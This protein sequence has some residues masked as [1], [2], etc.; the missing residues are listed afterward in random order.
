MPVF[1]NVPAVVGA[2]SVITTVACPPLARS[3]RPQETTLFSMTHGLDAPFTVAATYPVPSAR[4]SV[5]VAAVAVEPLFLT[6]EV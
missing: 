3:P 5:S 1:E 2:V 4:S 6:W